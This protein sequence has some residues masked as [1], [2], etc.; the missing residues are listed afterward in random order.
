VSH[1][2][3][4]LLQAIKPGSEVQIRLEMQGTVSGDELTPLSDIS[5][6]FTKVWALQVTRKTA[7]SRLGSDLRQ[8]VCSFVA[9][10]WHVSL[11]VPGQLDST[12]GRLDLDGALRATKIVPAERWTKRSQ[13]ALL[14]SPSETSLDKDE[15]TAERKRAFDLLDALSRSGALTIEC[16]SLHVMVA[17]THCFSKSLVDTVVLDNVNP[18]EKVERSS[19]IVASAIHDVSAAELIQADQVDRVRTHSALLLA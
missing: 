18:I 4:L 16:A 17:V 6:D 12:F 11:Q 9:V 15:Q 13:K 2:I 3:N 1:P 8:R 10:T 5:I 19:L 14:A 7:H